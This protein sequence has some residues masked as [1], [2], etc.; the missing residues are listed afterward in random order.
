MTAP[1]LRPEWPPVEHVGAAMTLRAGGLSPAPFDS[2]NLGLYVGDARAADNRRQ[3][4]AALALPAEPLWLRQVHG[5]ACPPAQALAPEAEADATWSERPGQVLAVQTADCLPVLFAAAGG[6]AVAAA[7]AGWRG[8][9]DGVLENTLA[10]MPVAAADVHC[11]LG[12]AI[13]PCCFEVGDEV[14]A[15][16]AARGDDVAVAFVET[17]RGKWLADLYALARGRL[18]AA[19]VRSIHGG[20]LCTACDRERFFSYRRDGG[21]TGRMATLIWRR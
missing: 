6:R 19:G 8:L 20:G 4:A 21:Q 7:H 12:A 13:G 18:H 1:C 10:A 3:L 14:R 17:G 2:N 11:W 15:A 16:F 5:T 9:L